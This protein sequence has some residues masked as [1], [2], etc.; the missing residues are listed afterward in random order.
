MSGRPGRARTLIG[1][2]AAI[3]AALCYSS[4]LL[5]PWLDP[6]SPAANGFVSE[7]EDPGQPFAWLYRTSDVVAGLG[8][9][10][11][12]WAVW[13]LVAGRRWAKAGV[14]LLALTGIG[15]LLD[16]AAS[17]Q[18]DPSVS[19]SCA[20]A[21]HTAVGLLRQLLV[22]HTDSGLLGFAGSAAGAAVLGLV[23]AGRWPFW[24]RL[25]VA[26]GIAMASCGLADIVLL[27]VGASIGTAER[28]RILLTSGWFASIGFFLL[29]QRPASRPRRPRDA[30]PSRLRRSA[31]GSK[32]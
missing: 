29:T 9:L 23:L 18:C 12:A 28:V 15:S 11:A 2:A 14:A 19:A 1:G 30:P 27:L 13:P 10:V 6:G 21:E 17:M 24:G 4:F 32:R 26:L 22:L 25:Q 3:I 20:Q 16:P 7:L 8:I 31:L 5:S